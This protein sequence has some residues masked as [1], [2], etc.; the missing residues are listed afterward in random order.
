[1]GLLSEL[2]RRLRLRGLSRTARGV[3]RDRLTYLAPAKMRRLEDE[4]GRVQRN[5]IPG[6]LLEFG[7]ALG[8][9]AIVIAGH[10]GGGRRFHGF[11]VFDMI[12]PPTSEKDDERSKARY[13]TIAS[14]RSKGIAG[15][16]YYGYRANLFDEV[17]GS[18]ARYGLPV[19]GGT[20]QLHKGL[21]EE[22]WPGLEIA[23]VAFA[24]VDCDW[25]DPVRYCLDAVAD[26]L[27][28]GG[29]VLIDDYHD[30]GG[31]REAVNEFLAKRRDFALEPGPNPI[32]R[33]QAGA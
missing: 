28:P 4:L 17:K 3:L 16:Q 1:M 14:G 32:L 5:A 26:R 33:K 27:S 31:C 9:S 24:H 22:T 23:Q 2:G 10:A 12:P 21:F 11:D 6:D 20:V 7:V 19:N 8:G 29:G 18:F 15:D 13:E 25:Y 30:Y